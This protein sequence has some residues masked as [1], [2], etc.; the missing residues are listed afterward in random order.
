MAKKDTS[1][2]LEYILQKQQS[3]KLSG[4]SST[5]KSQLGNIPPA[6]SGMPSE[7]NILSE[8]KKINTSLNI[9]LNKNIVKMTKAIENSTNLLAGFMKGSRKQIPPQ[10]KNDLSQQDIEDKDFKSKELHLLEEI[11]DTL[12]IKEKTKKDDGFSWLTALTVAIAAAIAALRTWAK[13][14]KDVVK[15][16]ILALTPDSI[17]A[18]FSKSF[19]KWVKGLFKDLK[20]SGKQIADF[21]KP[22]SNVFKNIAESKW[23]KGLMKDFNLAGKQ[24]SSFFEMFKGT[25]NYINAAFTKA[26][27]KIKTLLKAESFMSLF[28]GISRVFESLGK[29]GRVFMKSALIFSRIFKPLGIIFAIFDTITGA[30]EGYK[31]EGIMGAI[32]GAIKGFFGDFIFGFF[33]LIKNGISFV[34]DKIGLKSISEALDSF[35]FVDM[36]KD[37]VDM[38]FHPIDTV[39]KLIENVSNWL[40]KIEIPGINFSMF[41]KK[42]EAGPWKPFSSLASSETPKAEPP[43]VMAPAIEVKPEQVV[44]PPA[45]QANAI[46]E[47][48][49]QNEGASMQQFAA[50]TNNI[51]NAPTTITKQTQNNLMKVNIRNQDTTIK[52]YYRSRFAT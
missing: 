12:K 47:Q 20:L 43:S 31:K 8:L 7:N 34:L 2:S 40:S 52:D 18:L 29:I 3:E 28:S 24:V 41:G 45:Y 46:Y 37:F 36:F 13:L 1:L 49:A 17:K 25:F 9:G 39:K 23:I 27:I 26:F 32:S 51:V 11:R 16:I 48:S 35:S 14:V 19:D 4:L 15:N 44:A 6:G 33:D 38:V 10:T 22:V 50:P 21:F 5:V 30:I 42:F